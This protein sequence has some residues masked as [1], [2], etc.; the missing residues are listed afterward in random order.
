MTFSEPITTG[1]TALLGIT[2]PIVSAPMAG[3]AGGALAAAVS[4]AGGLGLIGGGYGDE[5][6][7]RREFAVAGDA[8]VGCGFITW[9]LAERPALLDL[10]LSHRPAAVMLSF[11]DPAPFASAVKSAGAQLICQVQDLCQADRALHVGADVLVAQGSEAG[12]H[13]CGPRSTMTLVPEIADLVGAAGLTTP[14][15]AAG[16]IADGRGLAAALML[17]AAGVLCGSRFYAATEALSTGPAREMVAGADGDSSCRTDVFDVA[18]GHDWP[19]G[20][21]MNALRNAFTDRWDGAE[22][23]PAQMVA[24]YRAAVADEDYRVAAVIV[25]QAAGLIHGSAPAGQIVTEM[26]RDAAGLLS[27][28]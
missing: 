26:A 18:R 15:L 4:R 23:D 14:V 9:A 3:V 5:T 7:L 28:R 6:W 17:G 11:G 24:Q 13:G 12:G 16:G 10:A 22:P 25:G 19:P 2:H 8:T 20:H 1:F 21:T 27:G